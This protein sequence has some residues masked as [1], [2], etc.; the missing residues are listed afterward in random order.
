MPGETFPPVPPCSRAKPS[1]RSGGLRGDD[2]KKKLVGRKRHLLVETAGVLRSVV[3][4]AASIPDRHRG[5]WGLEAA[6]DADPP[7]RPIWAQMGRPGGSARSCAGLPRSI[8]GGDQSSLRRCVRGS[9]KRRTA[10]K[11][12]ALHQGVQVS[13]RR[14]VVKQTLSW[15]GRQRRLST[16]DERLASTEEG[17]INPVGIRLLLARLA[18]A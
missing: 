8:D 14:W 17:F 1:Q 5:Q 13:P 10:W 6:G 7:G 4:H 16:G 12:R 9:A 2:G 15:W 18:P 3:G 11:M